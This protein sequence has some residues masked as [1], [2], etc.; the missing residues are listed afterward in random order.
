MKARR[1]TAKGDAF[2]RLGQARSAFVLDERT[3]R[4]AT[5]RTTPEAPQALEAMLACPVGDN[6]FGLPLASVARVRR[7]EQSG[8]APSQARGF[9]GLTGEGGRIV[10]ILDLSVLI[11]VSGTP[12][13]QGYLAILAAPRNAALRLGALPSAVDVEPAPGDEAR[14]RIVSR[15]EFENRILT[16]LDLDELLPA[17]GSTA[18]P[19][20]GD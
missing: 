5:R 13:G 3:R 1:R 12:A 17:T 6:L 16:R 18:L 10:P 11:G 8:A 4:L 20:F 19:T 15:G 7:L 14:A 2:A 9:L